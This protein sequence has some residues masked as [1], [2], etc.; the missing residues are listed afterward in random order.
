M[1]EGRTQKASVGLGGVVVGGWRRGCWRL[2][3]EGEG[4]RVGHGD[5][6]L[7][8]EDRAGSPPFQC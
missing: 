1:E 8:A 5:A 6:L 3:L 7:A 2:R 4:L